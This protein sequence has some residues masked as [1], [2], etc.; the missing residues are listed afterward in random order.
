M[1]EIERKKRE[2]FS[3]AYNQVNGSFMDLFAKLTGGGS[4]WLQLE[5]PE[6]PFAGDLDIFVQF[7]G[8]A[9]RLVSGASGGEKSVA[10]VSFIFALQRMQPAAF[11][12]FDEIDAHLD[13]YNAERLA[14]LLKGQAGGSQFI[15][16]TLR[17]VIVDRA[18]SLFGVYVHQGVS[19]VVSIRIPQLVA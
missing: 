14:D 8:K 11:Y 6:D 2:V 16:I 4:G 19:R 13:P 7:P 17:D 1:E 15:V 3:Q 18:E 12:I 9:A 5:N 10:A